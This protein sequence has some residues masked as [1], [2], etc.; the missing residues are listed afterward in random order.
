MP[1][2]SQTRQVEILEASQATCPKTTVCVQ[3]AVSADSIPLL[4]PATSSQAHGQLVE[5]P[6]PF[7]I[8]ESHFPLSLRQ[9]LHTQQ[10]LTATDKK[11]VTAG[12][13]EEITKYT[14]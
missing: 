12:L 1:G 2:N 10:D 14:L 4:Q 11:N 3:R 5:W 9:A 6:V 7:K 13:Y 8:N